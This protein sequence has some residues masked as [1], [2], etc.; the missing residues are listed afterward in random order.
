[1]AAVLSGQGAHRICGGIGVRLSFRLGGFTGY[2]L[3]RGYGF[4]AGVGETILGEF[5]SIE[6][7]VRAILKWIVND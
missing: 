1:M 3:D 4:E 6:A 7:A 2:I 5:A